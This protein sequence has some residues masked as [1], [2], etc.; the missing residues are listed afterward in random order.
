MARAGAPPAATPPVALS[1]PRGAPRGLA[2]TGK[3][4]QDW[5]VSQFEIWVSGYAYR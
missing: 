1:P 4:I 5:V 3:A 2:S